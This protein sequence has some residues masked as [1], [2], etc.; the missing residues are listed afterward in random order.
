MR[1][2]LFAVP[3]SV[4]KPWNAEAAA[5]A[6][7]TRTRF[8]DLDKAWAGLEFVLR[9]D[10]GNV[11]ED[12]V[13]GHPLSG[14]RFDEPDEIGWLS[15]SD[16]SCIADNF[17]AHDA[18]G[19]AEMADWFRRAYDAAELAEQGVYPRE[20]WRADGAGALEYLLGYLDQLMTFY[21]PF[22]DEASRGNGLISELSV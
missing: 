12:A 3:E 6:M 18:E 9:K 15:W 1:V 2:R 5:E 22:L 11:W 19:R 13:R 4:L 20:V 7:R 10:T 21:H 14:S 17:G 16:A 8:L